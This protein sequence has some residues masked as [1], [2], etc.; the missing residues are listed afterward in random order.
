MGNLNFIRRRASIFVFSCIFSCLG[1]S[2]G[3]AHVSPVDGIDWTFE[4]TMGF[5]NLNNMMSKE[6]SSSSQTKEALFFYGIL[7]HAYYNKLPLIKAQMNLGFS[8]QK[9]ILWTDNPNFN[10]ADQM[11]NES[12]RCTEVDVHYLMPSV[13]GYRGFFYPFVGYSFLNYSYY[14]SYSTDSKKT[15]QYH[16]FFAGLEYSTRINKYL[17]HD[18]Y[19]S[20]SPLMLNNSGKKRY[21]YYNYGTEVSISAHPVAVKVFLAFRNGF[22]KDSRLFDKETYIFSNSEIGLSF[23]VNLQNLR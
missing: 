18:Y 20:F 17:S 1:F 8:E 13:I 2:K 14:P 5:Q 7:Y 9:N 21:F 16:A 23:R 22:N 15:F 11:L 4:T 6:G 10:H 19:F 3:V 12:L